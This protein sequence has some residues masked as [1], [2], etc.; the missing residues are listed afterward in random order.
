V[1]LVIHWQH[2][3]SVEEYLQGFG[4]AGRDGQPALALL[5]TDPRD[6]GLL[7]YIVRF[8]NCIEARRARRI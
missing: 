7:K 5:F 4:R 3:F 8:A 6:A 2:T 1:R